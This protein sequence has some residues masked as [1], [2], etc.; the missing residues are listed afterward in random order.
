MTTR[1]TNSLVSIEE[2]AFNVGSWTAQLK[3]S[4]LPFH[5]AYTGGTPEQQRDLRVR[6]SCAHI[7]GALQAREN[8]RAEAKGTTA[9][10][11]PLSEATAIREAGK[12]GSASKAHK[13]LIDCAYADFRYNVVRPAAKAV[14]RSEVT[15]PAAVLAHLQAI[16]G[17][18]AT[19]PEM[20]A[21]CNAYIS[22]AAK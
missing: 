1:N 14:G 8:T 18:V 13:A 4:A 7:Q 9:R 19:Y 5:K 15:I 20:R 12:G 21:M 2:F 16:D 10:V 22:E 6:W 3:E 11:V 17:L